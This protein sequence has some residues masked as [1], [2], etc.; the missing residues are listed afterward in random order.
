MLVAIALRE[1]SAPRITTSTSTA[2]PSAAAA[3]EAVSP[4]SQSVPVTKR[5]RFRQQQHDPDVEQRVERE[6]P[7]V[8]ERRVLDGIREQEVELAERRAGEREGDEAPGQA[9]ARDEQGPRRGDRDRDQEE[10]VVEP[11]VDDP[12][13]CGTGSGTRSPTK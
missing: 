2:E 3:T 9:V 12:L 10:A 6:P 5:A 4:S 8:R 11:D 1:P 13:H 7:G